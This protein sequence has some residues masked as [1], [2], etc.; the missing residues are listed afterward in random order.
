MHLPC[1][2]A[3]LVG[4]ALAGTVVSLALRP[5]QPSAAEISAA[6]S[7]ILADL[8]EEERTS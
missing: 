7:E 6:A 2:L 4:G 5:R 3:G 8:A 1:I